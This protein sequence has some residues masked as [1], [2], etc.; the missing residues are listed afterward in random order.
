MIGILRKYKVFFEMYN[1]FHRDQLT[2][3]GP[4]YKKYGIKKSCFD[5]VSSK[6]FK[7]LRG[8][9]IGWERSV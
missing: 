1:F 2:H 9:E 5:S 7:H 8:E 6:D 4:I 3:N